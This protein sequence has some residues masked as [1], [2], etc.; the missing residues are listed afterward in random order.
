MLLLQ[1]GSRN[2]YWGGGQSLV[3]KGLLNFVVANYFPHKLWLHIRN[4][5]DVS[6]KKPASLK[7]IYYPFDGSGLIAKGGGVLRIPRTLP[8]DPPLFCEH[9]L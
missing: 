7:V 5:D 4:F 3:Q 6:V 1:G 8:Y 2:C 9:N